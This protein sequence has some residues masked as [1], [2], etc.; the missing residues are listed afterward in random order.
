MRY[1]SKYLFDAVFNVVADIINK[2][3]LGLDSE[4]LRNLGAANEFGE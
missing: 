1:K 4:Y 2:Y 3:T